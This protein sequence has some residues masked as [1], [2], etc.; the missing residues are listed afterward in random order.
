MISKERGY[1]ENEEENNFYTGS[2]ECRSSSNENG[3][4]IVLR[5]QQRA[6]IRDWM[7]DVT[8]KP[9]MEVPVKPNFHG[10][11]LKYHNN[12]VH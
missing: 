3:W 6:V 11:V 4:R 2:V 1:T 8:D 10:H 5:G 7:G 9:P 12:A